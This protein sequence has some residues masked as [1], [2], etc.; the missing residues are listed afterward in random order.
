MFPTVTFTQADRGWRYQLPPLVAEDQQE[1]EITYI[2]EF[3]STGDCFEYDPVNNTLTL[4]QEFELQIINGEIVNIKE[5]YAMLLF[6]LDSNVLGNAND[7]IEVL[8]LEFTVS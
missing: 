3:S 6:N 8:M 1:V 2:K 5:K 4:N 7:Q